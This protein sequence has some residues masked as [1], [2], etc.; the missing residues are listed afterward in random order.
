MW[1]SK[2]KWKA[3]EKKV[4]DLEEKVQGQQN[5]MVDSNHIYERM[6]QSFE[7]QLKRTGN[8]PFGV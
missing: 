8:S 3:I 6:K 7:E 2:K 4:A 5:V 1:I